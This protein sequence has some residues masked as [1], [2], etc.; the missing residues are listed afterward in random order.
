QR[1][2]GTPIVD[3]IRQE[4]D[5]P[6]F[7]I[8]VAQAVYC[9]GQTHSDGGSA[10]EQAGLNLLKQ[11]FQYPVI[12]GERTLGKSFT[13]VDHQSDPVGRALVNEIDGHTT[14]S[15]EPVWLK[16]L[17]EHTGRNIERNY[18]VNS[19]AG[20]IFPFRLTLRTGKG[21]DDERQRSSAEQKQ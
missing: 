4:N 17:C 9:G 7:C 18:N 2:N 14:G 20:F 11:I 15:F 16:I 3:T 6:A 1:R 12:G 10:F 5:D 8:A 19:F 21:D 13:F